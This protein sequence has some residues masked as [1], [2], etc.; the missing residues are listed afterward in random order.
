MKNKL[1]FIILLNLFFSL[2]FLG[3][4]SDNIQYKAIEHKCPSIS[5]QRKKI[6][7]IHLDAKIVK[8]SNKTYVAIPKNEFLNLIKDYKKTKLE[9]N[10]TYNIIDLFNNKVKNY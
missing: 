2:F 4:A 6:K 10:N 1:Y 5:I 8:I 3:C 9:L 7:K